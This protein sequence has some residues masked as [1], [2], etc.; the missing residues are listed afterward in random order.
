MDSS[1]PPNQNQKN[2]GKHTISGNLGVLHVHPTQPNKLITA[3]GVV[4]SRP[5]SKQ[6]QKKHKQA[7]LSQ[8]L[9]DQ[10]ISNGTVQITSQ[11]QY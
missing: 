7:L 11:N 10:N 5:K 1:S 3:S 9:I 4:I 2:G 6:Q 8:Q